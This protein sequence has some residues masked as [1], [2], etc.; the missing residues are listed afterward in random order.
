MLN[1]NRVVSLSPGNGN[2]I[3]NGSAAAAGTPELKGGLM[4]G[5]K[6]HL[7]RIR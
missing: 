6:W 4:L 3:N 2:T 7:H 5:R 1:I